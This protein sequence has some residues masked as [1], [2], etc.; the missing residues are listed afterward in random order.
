MLKIID[1]RRLSNGWEEG[2]FERPVIC[3]TARNVGFLANSSFTRPFASFLQVSLPPIDLKFVG[4]LVVQG[5]TF[6]FSGNIYK[7]PNV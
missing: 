1:E 5:T 7:D 6:W 3:G 4:Y 2:G